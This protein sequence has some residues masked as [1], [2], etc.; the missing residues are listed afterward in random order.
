MNPKIVL[1]FYV[2]TL[3]PGVARCRV[4]NCLQVLIKFSLIYC[5]R[6]GAGNQHRVVILHSCSGLHNIYVSAPTY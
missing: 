4:R 6:A 5:T 2:L 1:R 3:W